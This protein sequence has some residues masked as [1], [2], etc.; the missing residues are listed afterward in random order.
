MVTKITNLTYFRHGGSTSLIWGF[1]IPELK[2]LNPVLNCLFYPCYLAKLTHWKRLQC[3]E[4]LK[5]GE[6][7]DRG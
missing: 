2:L 5:A 6:G 4:R 1:L 7:D 3:W